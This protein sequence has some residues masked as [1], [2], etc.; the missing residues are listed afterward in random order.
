MDSIDRVAKPRSRTRTTVG[1][2]VVLLLVAL[3][4]GVLVAGFSSGGSATTIT[5]STAD[6]SAP[7][8]ASGGPSPET[9]APGEVTPG[10]GFSDGDE[11]PDEAMSVP[12]L[13]HLVGAVANPGLYELAAGDRVVDAVAAAGGL[14]PD[15]DEAR[16]NLARPVSDGE[17][18]LVPRVGEA[19]PVVEGDGAR[20]APGPSAPVNLNTADAA[21]LD[22]LPGVGPATARN[23]LDWR[24]ANGRFT[25]VEDLLSVTGI[26]EKT[27]SELRDLVTV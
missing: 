24:E 22:S 10:P 20:G 9:G 6:A 14:A 21:A 12:L 2:V 23:I 7:A 11:P 19:I 18:I 3:V 1:A 26:G 13:V 4:A 15:A 25:A 5:D 27:L 16:V 8:T 17:Q